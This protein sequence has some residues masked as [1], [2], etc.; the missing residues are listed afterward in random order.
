MRNRIITTTISKPIKLRFTSLHQARALIKMEEEAD[1][2]ASSPCDNGFELKDQQ[3]PPPLERRALLS[4]K[5]SSHSRRPQFWVRLFPLRLLRTLPWPSSIVA[6]V[7]ELLMLPPSLAVF[8]PP[9]SPYCI[10]LIGSSG[11]MSPS[12]IFVKIMRANL[13]NISST[14]SPLSA[15]ASV[16]TEM[17]AVLAQR[18]ASTDVTSR[19][20]GA[21][22]ARCCV[23]ALIELLCSRPVAVLL[24]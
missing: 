17:P 14:P 15:L 3:Q 2:Q 20:S 24:E 13:P 5:T 6:P 10:P 9:L 23:P 7:I 21:I 8:H 12:S 4:V 19:P 18:L 1:R 22:V 11:S 16:T